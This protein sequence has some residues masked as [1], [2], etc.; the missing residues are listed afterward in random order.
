MGAPYQKARRPGT[1]SVA[2]RGIRYVA[3]AP[4]KPGE[5]EGVIIAKCDTQYQAEQA[6]TAW[7]TA[8]N[9]A[10]SIE[11]VGS[12]LLL[13][14]ADAQVLANMLCHRLRELVAAQPHIRVSFEVI[15]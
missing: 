11:V 15:P 5:K 9:L 1:G 12:R 6:L 7:M 13:C 10:I 14:N 8:N 3:R 4:R 2:K